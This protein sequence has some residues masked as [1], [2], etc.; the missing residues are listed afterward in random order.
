MPHI[1]VD[2][3]IMFW[4]LSVL[5]MTIGN[6]VA[7][8]QQNI[9]RMLAYSSIA[10][11]GYILIGFVAGAKLGISAVL[12]YVL[13][14]AFMTAGAFAMVI[15]LR[16]ETVKGDLIEDFAGLGQAKPIAAAAMLVFLLSLTGIP[17]TAGFVGKFYIF[18][19]A[20][21]A[22][23]VWLALI[24]VINTA[25]SL[26]YYMRVAMVMYMREPPKALVVSPSRPLHVAVAFAVLGTL[27]IGIYP[28][29]FLEF[30]QASILGLLQ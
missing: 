4:I 26:F 5:T 15:L 23:Y 30:A 12:F 7:M 2:W 29:P 14:Y 16:T 19:A 8:A 20:I 17:P 25:I 18:G 11:I 6:V 28:G 22:G 3:T 1:Q 24:A 9:K 21:K 13:V 10:H 27:I